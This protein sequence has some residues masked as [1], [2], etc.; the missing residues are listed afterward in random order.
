MTIIR[1]YY[2]DHY[3]NGM[4]ISVTLMIRLSSANNISVDIQ[5]G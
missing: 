5:N 1:Q 3:Y 2:G 4:A